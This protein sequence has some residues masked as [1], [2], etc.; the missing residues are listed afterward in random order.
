MWQASGAEL[1]RDDYVTRFPRLLAIEAD[2][3]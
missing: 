1:V 3:S 2:R